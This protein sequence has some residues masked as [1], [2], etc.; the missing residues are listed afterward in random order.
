MLIKPAFVPLYEVLFSF[1]LSFPGLFSHSFGNSL[2]GL[3][4]VKLFKKT[5]DQG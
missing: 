2:E 1:L 3:S 4:I 5:E